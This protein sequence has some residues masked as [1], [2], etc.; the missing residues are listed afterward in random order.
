MA[1]LPGA[2]A[3]RVDGAAVAKGARTA[4]APGALLDLS[5]EGGDLVLQA[6]RDEH[7]HA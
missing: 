6:Q 1:D 5:G 3:L 4:V 7:A 2:H